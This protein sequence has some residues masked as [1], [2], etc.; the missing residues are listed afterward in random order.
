MEVTSTRQVYSNPWL[1]LRE[2]TVLRDGREE[3]YTVIER[4]D[5]V[6]IVPISSSGTTVLLQ[7]D[8]HPI[9][10]TSWELPMGGIDP[11]EDIAAAAAREFREEV[12]VEVEHLDDAGW[13]HPVPALSAQRATVFVARFTESDEAVQVRNVDDIIGRR[14]VPFTEVFEMIRRHEVTDGFTLIGLLLADTWIRP[15]LVG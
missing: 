6:I 11:G 2:D 8:R 3:P 1:A 9:T 13:F 12:G 15:H 4:S 7:Q 10:S 14:F 5:S